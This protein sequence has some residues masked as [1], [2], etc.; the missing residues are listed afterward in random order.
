MGVVRKAPWEGLTGP[1][2]RSTG[3]QP[4]ALLGGSFATGYTL[5]KLIRWRGHGHPDD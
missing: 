3:L 5:A 1:L 2:K 4:W